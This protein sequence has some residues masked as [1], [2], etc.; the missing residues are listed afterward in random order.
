MHEFGLVA[1]ND[2][3][4]VFEPEWTTVRP[5]LKQKSIIDYIITDKAILRKASGVVHVDTLIIGCL[6]HFLV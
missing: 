4:L 5:S 2:R 6:D 1:S 3:K